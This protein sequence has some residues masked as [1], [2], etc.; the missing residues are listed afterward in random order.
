MRCDGLPCTSSFWIFFQFSLVRRAGRQAMRHVA[1][2]DAWWRN[3]QPPMDRWWD[4]LGPAATL[5]LRELN[6]PTNSE[7]GI[8]PRWKLL[9]DGCRQ[10]STRNSGYIDRWEFKQLLVRLGPYVFKY[11]LFASQPCARYYFLAIG[12]IWSLACKCN[13]SL[14]CSGPERKPEALLSGACVSL[15]L[16]RRIQTHTRPWSA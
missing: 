13:C 15:S 10:A 11:G 9:Q 3:T 1:V 4:S 5:I 6:L 8:V 7:I 16:W 14:A 12:Y 2:R